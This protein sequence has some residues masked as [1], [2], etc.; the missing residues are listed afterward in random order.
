MRRDLSLSRLI[1][2]SQGGCVYRTEGRAT[3]EPDVLFVIFIWKGV[4]FLGSS[5]GFYHDFP[6]VCTFIYCVY[7]RRFHV[8]FFAGPL[9][10]GDL[11]WNCVLYTH[12]VYSLWMRTISCIFCEDMISPPPSVTTIAAQKTNREDEMSH[13]DPPFSIISSLPWFSGLFSRLIRLCFITWKKWSVT[14]ELSL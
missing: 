5:Y 11:P 1:C 4:N 12:T 13:P 7:N 6:P 3:E 2:V 10:R 9:L 14:D 8:F